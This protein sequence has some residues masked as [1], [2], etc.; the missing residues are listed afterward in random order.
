MIVNAEVSA[1]TCAAPAMSAFG[2]MVKLARVAVDS[3]ANQRSMNFQN[4][5]DMRWLERQ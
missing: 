2:S 1:N 4:R 3:T 5:S